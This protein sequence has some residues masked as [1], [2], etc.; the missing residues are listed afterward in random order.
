M[1]AGAAAD[2][3]TAACAGDGEAFGRVFDAH[4]NA[5]F[6]HAL[7]L[8]DSV[9]DAEDVTA[10]AFLELWR[11]RADVR[12]VGGSPLPWLL[13]TTTNVARNLRRATLRYRRL[14]ASLPRA[15]HAL[16]PADYVDVVSPDL[17][18]ALR[19]LSTPDLRLVTLVVVE[20]LPI[21]DAAAVLGIT[22]GAAKVRL[23]RARGRL[24]THLT[25]PTVVP[26]GGS[27]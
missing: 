4:R 15:Q 19:L 16:D 21:A 20:G 13:V 27:R 1:T 5:V 26:A 6:R 10:A 7:R 18:A 8:V 17:A 12:L 24:R 9:A 23:H 22:P 3:W 2:D 25:P 14:L 11:R